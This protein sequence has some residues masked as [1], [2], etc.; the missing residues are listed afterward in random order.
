M[1]KE[2]ARERR[3]AILLGC[4]LSEEGAD[5]NLLQ[6]AE[7]TAQQIVAAKLGQRDVYGQE[8]TSDHKSASRGLQS[9]RIC[10]N[11]AYGEDYQSCQRR[12]QGPTGRGSLAMGFSFGLYLVHS[13]YDWS[14]VDS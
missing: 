3:R 4:G 13:S 10:P 14:L 5:Y 2:G 1:V 12:R 9:D 11:V 8:D 7:Q 6:Q